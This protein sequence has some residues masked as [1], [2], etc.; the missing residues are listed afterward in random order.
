MGK[1]GFNS[2]LGIKNEK[3]KILHFELFYRLYRHTAPRTEGRGDADVQ[4]RRHQGLPL[5]TRES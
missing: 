1:V 4:P 5:N 2:I 3:L